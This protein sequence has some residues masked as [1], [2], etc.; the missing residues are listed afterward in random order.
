MNKVAAL[1]SQELQGIKVYPA[2]GDRDLYP[3]NQFSFFDPSKNKA[4]NEWSNS[5]F[6]FIPSHEEF[7]RF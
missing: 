7:A 1:I 6:Q 5:W 2:I 3:L 4:F